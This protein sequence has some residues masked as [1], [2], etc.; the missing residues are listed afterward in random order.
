MFKLGS[1]RSQLVTEP[2]F[3]TKPDLVTPVIPSAGPPLPNDPSLQSTWS[4]WAWVATGC[5]TLIFSLAKTLMGAAMWFEPMVAGYVG[6][7]LDDLLSGVYHWG[8]DNYGGQASTP[9]FGS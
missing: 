9:V 7:V 2:R 5:T 8:I 4:N 1:S 3:E 6:Y